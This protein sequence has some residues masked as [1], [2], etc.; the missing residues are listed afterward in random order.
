MVWKQVNP[1]QSIY[2]IQFVY[3]QRPLAFKEFK[4]MK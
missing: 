1:Q 2:I 4:H 3:L